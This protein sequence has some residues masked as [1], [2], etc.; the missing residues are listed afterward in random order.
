MKYGKAQE[1]F[2]GPKMYNF[3]I[4][5]FFKTPCIY[6]ASKSA[7]GDLQDVPSPLIKL[8]QQQGARKVKDACSS[9]G[10]WTEWRKIDASD[11]FITLPKGW[12]CGN[13]VCWS[14]HRLMQ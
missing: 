5:Y 3:A 2:K 11:S 14:H 4:I 12:M 6:S 13:T 7:C 9:F 8:H 1:T 10:K